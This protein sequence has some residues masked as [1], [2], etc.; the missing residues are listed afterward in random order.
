MAV[1]ELVD[2]IRLSFASD[3][4]CYRC[5]DNPVVSASHAFLQL[6]QALFN[7]LGMLRFSPRLPR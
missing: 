7:V 1:K 6:E 2:E 4:W 3:L 5:V